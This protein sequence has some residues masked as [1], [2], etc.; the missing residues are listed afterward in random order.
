MNEEVERVL[1]AWNNFV[2]E[3]DKV[4]YEKL[5]EMIGEIG[6]D[7][8]N[9][10]DL[11]RAQKPPDDVRDI[12]TELPEIY[13]PIGNG[14]NVREGYIV[15]N[16]GETEKFSNPFYNRDMTEYLCARRIFPNKEYAEM[17]RDKTKFIADC[18][19][20]K[21]LYDRNY[22]YE[23]KA[24]TK[25]WRVCYDYDLNA[26]NATWDSNREN[27]M[28]VYFSTEYLAGKCAEWLNLMYKCGEYSEGNDE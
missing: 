17:F 3:V 16:Y 12:P 5:K 20:F 6:I 1:N 10:L 23:P 22:D 18:L 26:Y 28:T 13:F 19:H 25:E 8:I 21:W 2:K 14:R 4:G 11:A 15:T 7:V 9:R 27:A 24:Y